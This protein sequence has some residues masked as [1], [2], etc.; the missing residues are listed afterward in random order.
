MRQLSLLDS[1]EIPVRLPGLA[2]GG[3]SRVSNSERVTE[4]GL[5]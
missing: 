4:L 1:P 3:R 5:W 2:R